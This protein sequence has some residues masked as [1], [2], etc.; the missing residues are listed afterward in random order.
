MKVA[1]IAYGNIRG[2]TTVIGFDEKEIVVCE[3]TLIEQISAKGR[4][5]YNCVAHRRA[6]TI[7]PPRQ[8]VDA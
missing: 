5:H 4:I 3:G 7:T 6:F 2:H 8:A 1:S